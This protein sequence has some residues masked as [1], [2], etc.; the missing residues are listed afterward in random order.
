MMG[1]DIRP[2]KLG[3]REIG[4]RQHRVLRGEAHVEA[5]RAR[6][7]GIKS[8]QYRDDG[9]ALPAALERREQALK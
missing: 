6:Y 9:V 5:Q 7:F 1:F 4:A 8:L 2:R 3:G